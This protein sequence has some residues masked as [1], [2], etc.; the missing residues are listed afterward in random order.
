MTNMIKISLK[1][2]KF[3]SPYSR[4]EVLRP[5]LELGELYVEP[6]GM[7][8]AIEPERVLEFRTS[9]GGGEYELPPSVFIA[10]RTRDGSKVYRLVVTY[11]GTT[12]A[13][14]MCVPVPVPT[15]S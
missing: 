12:G 10:A 8:L 2:C 3:D 7:Y 13:V 9:E 1:G 5:L 6:S 4:S 14:D 15:A 11:D